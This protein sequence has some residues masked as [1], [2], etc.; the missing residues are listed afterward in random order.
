MWKK[1]KR[2]KGERKKEDRVKKDMEGG[3]EEGIEGMRNESGGKEKKR[4]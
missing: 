3:R 4:V 1:D 2:G